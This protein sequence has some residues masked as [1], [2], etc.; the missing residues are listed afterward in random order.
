MLD[1]R[2]DG[3]LRTFVKAVFF[4]HSG[5]KNVLSVALP[6]LLIPPIEPA[7]SCL[8]AVFF[9]ILYKLAIALFDISSFY[10]SSLDSLN[11]FKYF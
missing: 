1:R 4:I 10:S 8:S 11:G 2:I 5:P 3:L 7:K 6:I 9:F